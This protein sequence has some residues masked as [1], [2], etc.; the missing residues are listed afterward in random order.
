MS[1][2]REICTGSGAIV[3]GVIALLWPGGPNVLMM[4]AAI[5]LFAAFLLEPQEED[6]GERPEEQDH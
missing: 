5:V 3:L 4:F 6:H 1:S 2:T